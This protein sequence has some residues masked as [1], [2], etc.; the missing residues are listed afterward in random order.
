MNKHTRSTR[1]RTIHWAAASAL[2]LVIAGCQSVDNNSPNSYTG[3]L[4]YTRD[5]LENEA[6]SPQKTYLDSG[7]KKTQAEEPVNNS[8]DIAEHSTAEASSLQES[9]ANAASTLKNKEADW[10]ATKPQLHG[11]AIGDG[12]DKIKLLHGKESD[13]YQLKEEAEV[14]EVLE[15]DGFS[16]GINKN[17]KVQFVEVYD[18]HV[19]AGLNGLR[20]GDKPEKVLDELGKPKTQTDFLLTYEADGA[21]LKL[22]LDPQNQKIISIKLLAHS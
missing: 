1:S 16:V 19:A 10:T 18:E 7:N 20:I 11:I 8:D 3:S 21:L 15:Y 9:A 12:S 14:I 17:N 2:A 22:D 6:D 5:Q 13:S 4:S